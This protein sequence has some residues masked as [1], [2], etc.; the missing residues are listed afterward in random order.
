[1]KC[2]CAVCGEE[3]QESERRYELRFGAPILLPHQKC[4]ALKRAEM[5]KYDEQYDYNRKKKKR[6]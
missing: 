2:V 3:I 1:M 4:I 5:R 6:P